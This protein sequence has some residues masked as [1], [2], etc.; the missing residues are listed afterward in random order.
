VSRMLHT[1]LKYTRYVLA[2]LANVGFG[3]AMN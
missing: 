3:M 2:A 1:A